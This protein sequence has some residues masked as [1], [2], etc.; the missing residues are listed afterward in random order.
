MT[1]AQQLRD[2]LRAAHT[3]IRNALAVMTLEQKSE[4]GC[5]N[6][7]DGVAGEGV[8]RHHERQTVIAEGSRL[9]LFLELRRAD[10][11]IANAWDIQSFHQHALWS[12][13]NQ[14]DGVAATHP[15]RAD[16]RSIALA[17]AVDAAQ[18]LVG[19]ARG[20]IADSIV[21]F[22]R[23]LGDK[24]SARVAWCGFDASAPADDQTVVVL[25]AKR[26]V[27]EAEIAELRRLLAT[28]PRHGS[29]FV[30][31]PAAQTT[32]A[33]IDVEAMLRDCVPG[34]DF[35]DPQ[36]VADSIRAW[37]ADAESACDSPT[38]PQPQPMAR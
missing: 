34:G 16:S 10:R 25:M 28:M 8:T 6:E 29:L 12:I 14:Q 37:F 36:C 31:R 21:E 3:V 1:I 15:T 9:G 24:T 38:I 22:V 30:E 19:D 13:A 20:E 26:E 32:S 4:W 17:A 2:E 11:I 27:S 35:C 7:R 33:R 18:E 5:A 23:R